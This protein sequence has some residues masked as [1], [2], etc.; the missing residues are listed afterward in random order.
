MQIDLINGES[1]NESR[2]YENSEKIDW[3]EKKKKKQS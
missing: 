1:R 3:I 2:D